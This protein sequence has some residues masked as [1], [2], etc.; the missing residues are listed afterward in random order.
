[1]NRIKRVREYVPRPVR[2]P[3]ATTLRG[4]GSPAALRRRLDRA[5]APGKAAPSGNR[6][7]KPR[8]PRRPQP[9]ATT[10]RGPAKF[11][12]SPGRRISVAPS[13]VHGAGSASRRS[14]ILLELGLGGKFQAKSSGWDENRTFLEGDVLEV[15]VRNGRRAL[16]HVPAGPRS[17]PLRP[18]TFSDRGSDGVTGVCDIVT[19]AATPLRYRVTGH[20]AGNSRC[21][22]GRQSWTGRS[23]RQRRGSSSAVSG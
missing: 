16:I 8:E 19:W 18:S 12:V 5:A 11:A 2:Q 17:A 3:G 7:I 22:R 6:Q 4:A 1:V 10:L 20:L 13:G 21:G 9:D 14:S 23:L 15:A